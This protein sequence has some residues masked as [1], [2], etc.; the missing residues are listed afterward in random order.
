M[1]GPATTTTP[2]LF[3]Y[4]GISA[5]ETA[6]L[7]CR[8]VEAECL[9]V[10]DGSAAWKP[11]EA[12]ASG[13]VLLQVVGEFVLEVSGDRQ[14]VLSAF[15]CDYEVQ[16]EIL[17]KASPVSVIATQIPSKLGEADGIRFL[18]RDESS[19]TVELAVCPEWR[20]KL[21]MFGKILGKKFIVQ[22]GFH[23]SFKAIKK[24]GRGMTACVYNAINFANG[25]E[26]A[27]KSFKRSVYFAQDNG[28]GK[29][30]FQKEFRILTQIN[31]K[32]LSQIYSVF[33][34]ENSTYVIL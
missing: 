21:E 1:L 22:L 24:I 19:R 33:E 18:F 28:N 27:I 14:Q 20:K 15:R 12:S 9:F 32:N 26:V 34:T 5:T 31:H 11:E 29:I 3:A 30:S 10:R 8:P 17:R 4:Q 6:E 13:C 16:F 25:R 23:T 2:L 7:Q